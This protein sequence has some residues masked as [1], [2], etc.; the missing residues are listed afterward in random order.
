MWPCWLLQFLPWKTREE[1]FYFF[2][3]LFLFF[4]AWLYFRFVFPYIQFHSVFTIWYVYNSEWRARGTQRKTGQDGASAWACMGFE[5]RAC[6]RELQKKTDRNLKAYK[7]RRQIGCIIFDPVWGREEN[8]WLVIK[9]SDVGAE[10]EWG[11][12]EA[13][14]R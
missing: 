14:L 9:W 10:R 3:N 12:A 11:A 4:L 6:V 1:I 5:A 8:W 2:C 13:F 7:S